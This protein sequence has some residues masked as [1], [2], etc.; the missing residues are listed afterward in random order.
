MHLSIS[1]DEYETISE[2][3]PCTAC[4]GDLRK[5]N[6]A[7]NGRLTIGMRRRSPEDAARLRAERQE[8]EDD[9]TL[10]RAAAIQARR[11]PIST[12]G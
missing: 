2:S 5:C 6:G 11:A 8:R 10:A 4:G 12:T 1:E 3:R 9:E 7:C